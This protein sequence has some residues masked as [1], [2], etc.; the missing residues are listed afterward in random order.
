ML[1]D[2]FGVSLKKKKKRILV[3][4]NDKKDEIPIKS[5]R[6]LIIFGKVNISSELIKALV[7]SGV[8]VLFTSFPRESPLQELLMPR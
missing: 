7:E 1:I 2:E 4:T 8:D 6:D 5:V 3:I